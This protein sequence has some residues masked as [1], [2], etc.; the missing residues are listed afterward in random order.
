LKFHDI[1]NIQIATREIA[2][3][4]QLLLI[5]SS[6]SP[7]APR[8]K[9]L[10]SNLIQFNALKDSRIHQECHGEKSY[11]PPFRMFYR[12]YQYHSTVRKPII[13][14]CQI[15]RAICASTALYLKAVQAQR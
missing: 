11:S 6:K 14:S 15:D 12:E 2:N 10:S 9:E 8:P 1:D 4:L 3:T 13:I 7:M 5:Y